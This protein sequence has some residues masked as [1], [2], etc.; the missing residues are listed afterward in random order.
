M[1]YA[2]IPACGASNRMGCPKLLLK[3]DGRTILERVIHS[4]RA[5]GVD[6]ILVVAHPQLPELVH[7]AVRAGAGSIQPAHETADMRETVAIGLGWVEENSSPNGDEGWFL[8]P[9]DHPCLDPEVVRRLIDARGRYRD[10]TVFVPVHAGR[11]GHP[12]L[13]AWSH[14]Y[15]ILKG[16]IPGGGLN[17]YIR[18]QEAVTHL[19]PVD[20]PGVL[21]DLDTPEDWRR[22]LASR[23]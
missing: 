17:H 1:N 20:S 7:V 19:V 8:V 22:I 6:Q 12:A 4:L 10:K 18:G 15:Q 3:L 9:A 11:R 5:G 16:R 14:A 2:I 21:G 23:S 13:L